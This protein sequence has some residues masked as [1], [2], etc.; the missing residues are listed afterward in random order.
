MKIAILGTGSVSQT[1]ALKLLSNGHD[2]ML[3]TRNVP[4]KLA[5]TTQDAYGNPPFSEWYAANNII[6][7]GTFAE[8]SAF[9]EVVINATQGAISIDALKLAGA[10]NLNGKVLIDIANPLDFSKGMTPCLVPE[11]S[12]LN[13]LGEEIQK[14]F[15]GAKVVKTLNTM[16]CGIMVNPAMIN[17]GDHVNFICGN[18]DKAKAIVRKL[19]NEFGWKDEN[20]LDLGDIQSARGT[21]AILPLWLKVMGVKKSGAFNFNIV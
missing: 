18:D 8:A 14:L 11:L 3:G 7:L 12:N 21:E 6:K 19:L 13:S 17:G 1:L 5:S 20:I 10:E 16:W 9:G 2:L 4:K 15:P